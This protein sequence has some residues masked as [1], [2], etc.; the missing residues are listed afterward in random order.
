MVV[1]TLPNAK[2][3]LSYPLWAC[4]FD[5]HDAN[6]LVVG[7]GGGAGRHGVGNKMTLL[8]LSSD[9]SREIENAGETELSGQEDS[10]ATIA[11]GARRDSTSSTSKTVFAGINA[12]PDECKKGKSR[13]FRVFGLAQPARSAKNSGV[14]FSETARE[15]LF[16]ST[17]ADTFQRRLRL[18]QPF[19]KLENN[20][21]AAAASSSSQLGAV[22]TGF[23]QQSQIAIFDAP[24]AGPQR[25]KS[26]GRLQI[27][28]EAMDLDVV[29][30]GPDT[31]QLAYCDDYEIF[32]VDISRTDVSE[33]RCVYT[34][35]S[36]D[37]PKARPSFKSI[38]YLSPG[39]VF[40][41]ANSPAGKGVLLHGYRLPEKDQERARLAVV[42]TLPKS[43]SRSTGLAVRNLA[44]P[45]SVQDK[46]GDSQYVIAVSGQDNSISLYTLEYKST[47]NIDLLVDLA[48]FAK[49][50]SV[51]PQAITGLSFSTSP[52]GPKPAANLELKLASVS[53]GQT[54]VVHSIPLKKY[55]D[56]KAAPRKGGPPRPARYVV[57]IPSQG[58]S[59][60][61]L[62][63][64]TAAICLL[65]ALIGQT[66][67]E[68]KGISQPVLGTNRFL[69]E[70]WT[71][72]FRVV[73]RE[74]S[75][76][77][78]TTFDDLLTTVTPAEHEKI[79]VRHDDTGEIGPDGLPQLKAHVHDEEL[80]GPA[81]PWDELETREQHLWRQRLKKTGHW[82]EDMGET[83]FKG[84]LFGEIGGAIGAMVGEAL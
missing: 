18:S 71:V 38:R 63:I 52:K 64:V 66:F 49:I 51:H 30:T 75:V 34:L 28:N 45:S 14:T 1:R 65:M 29:Q 12:A 41:V 67:M 26:R 74:G 72:P 20:A 19:E 25:W 5:P 48:P 81:K 60:L 55:V 4:D 47:L 43:V 21:A 68:A 44:P 23:A 11:V 77:K 6:Q 82:V 83:V 73:P 17:D 54:A 3:T 24:A 69:P 50:D 27:P 61:S 9:G 40:A 59:H 53:L 56:K 62:I 13:H 22:S 76:L 79:I 16:A 37:G 57:A 35:T 39:F 8:K 84:V 78:Q 80:H 46:Q 58:E 32:T 7:G 2:I 36:N 15:T 70:S 10:V 42:K 33:P 31:Y